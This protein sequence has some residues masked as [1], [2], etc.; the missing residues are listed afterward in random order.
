MAETA[1]V[2][3]KLKLLREEEAR[4]SK[5]LTKCRKCL[6]RSRKWWKVFEELINREKV[7]MRPFYCR[8]IEH[9]TKDV[10]SLYNEVLK[11]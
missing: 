8:I 5:E 9:K 2:T 6:Q 7:R 10:K 4:L 11:T 3:K 1:Y